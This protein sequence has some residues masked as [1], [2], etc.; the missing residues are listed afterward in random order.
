MIASN[1]E[2]ANHELVQGFE[3]AQAAGAKDVVVAREH[4]L[5]ELQAEAA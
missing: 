2:P 5:A 3:A 1:L 4:P